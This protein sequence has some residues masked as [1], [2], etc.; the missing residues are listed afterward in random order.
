MLHDLNETSCID[1]LKLLLDEDRL[2]VLGTVAA[3]RARNRRWPRNWASNRV[4]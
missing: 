2:R 3:G 4:R 1:L